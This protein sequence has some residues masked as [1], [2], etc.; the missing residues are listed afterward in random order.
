[1][2]SRLTN[3]KAT[4][5]HVHPRK[6]EIPSMEYGL[7][8]KLYL[9]KY[10]HLYLFLRPE[11]SDHL[12]IVFKLILGHFPDGGRCSFCFLFYVVHSLCAGISNMQPPPPPNNYRMDFS[13]KIMASKRGG[14]GEE[15]MRKRRKWHSKKIVLLGRWLELWNLN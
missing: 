12:F 13:K 8:R 7:Y 3:I 4:P 1:M 2:L 9:W 15:L 14:E 5:W 6:F 10:L 11:H